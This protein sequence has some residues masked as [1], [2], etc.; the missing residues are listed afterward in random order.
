MIQLIDKYK[1]ATNF[2]RLFMILIRHRESKK[3]S[4]DNETSEVNIIKNPSILSLKNFTKKHIF[5][6]KLIL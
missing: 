6:K 3:V 4:D 2:A 5:L 1:S